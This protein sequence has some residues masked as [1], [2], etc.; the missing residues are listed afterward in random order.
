MGRNKEKIKRESDRIISEIN[1]KAVW[2][3]FC[4]E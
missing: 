3:F 1:K 4:F 2:S